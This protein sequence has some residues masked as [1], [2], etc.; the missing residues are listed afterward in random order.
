[1]YGGTSRSRPPTREEIVEVIQVVP[2]ERDEN[3]EVETLLPR[4][5]DQ[6]RIAKQLV[7]LPRLQVHEEMV[8]AVNMVSDRRISEFTKVN[9][10]QLH[11]DGVE[12]E[13]VCRQ[14]WQGR[15]GFDQ[16]AARRVMH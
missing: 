10:S 9:P 1:M 6:H 7:D 2:Q 12:E 13:G 16:A 15:E 14:I 3:V 4:K 5:G 8:E 11:Q